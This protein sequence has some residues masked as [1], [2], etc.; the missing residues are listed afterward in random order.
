MLRGLKRV[1][2]LAVT[3]V[4]ALSCCCLAAGSAA[5]ERPPNFIVIFCDDMGYADIGP[6][7]AKDYKTP[8]LDRLARSSVL[9]TNTHCAAPACN[10]SRTAIFTGM[11]PLRDGG[12]IAEPISKTRCAS[13]TRIS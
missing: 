9:F 1:V 3:A 8:N 7:G 2:L 13:V 5:A 10:P 12:P 11:S 6:F 4:P